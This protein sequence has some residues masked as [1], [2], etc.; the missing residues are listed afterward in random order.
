MKIEQPAL[1]VAGDRDV[2]PFSDEAEQRMRAVVTD[3][4][5]VVVLPGIGHWTQQEAPEAVNEALLGFL[6]G[7]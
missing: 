4:R 1:F 6:K 7:L 2:V 3:L 5:D